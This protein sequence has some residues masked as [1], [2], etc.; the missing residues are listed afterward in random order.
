MIKVIKGTFALAKGLLITLK[1][2]FTP[3]VTQ[4]YPEEKRMPYR[5]Y[6]GIHYFRRGE[7]GEERCVAC[8]LCAAVCPNSCIFIEADESGDRVKHPERNYAK[9]YSIVME[10]CLYCGYCEEA[11]PKDAIALSR[12]Y[13]FVTESRADFMQTKDKLLAAGLKVDEESLG[14]EVCKAR[15]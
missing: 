15:K 12:K 13:D 14:G 7:R 5:G 11:C 3:S 9:R 6:R 8:G 10:R 2:F 4:Q 1:Y